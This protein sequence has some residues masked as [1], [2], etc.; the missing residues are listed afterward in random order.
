MKAA[1]IP[2]FLTRSWLREAASYLAAFFIF[3]LILLNRSPNVLRPL[4]MNIRFGFTWVIPVLAIVLYLCFRIPGRLGKFLSLTATLSLFALVLGGVWASGHTQ[5]TYISGLIPLYDAQNYYVDALRLL[6]GQRIS[7]FSAAR[8]LFTGFLATVLAITGRDLTIALMVLTAV[9]A[10]ACFFAAQTI[11][12]THGA[13]VAVFLLLFLF[14]YY[15]Y[16]TVGTVMSENVGFALGVTGITLLWRSIKNNSSQMAWY[17]LLLNAL[18][19]NARPGPFFILPALLLWGS[20]HFSKPD[21]HFSWRFFLAGIVAV[22]IGF[23]SSLLIKQFFGVE[24]GVPFSQFSYALYGLASG[25]NSWAYIFQVHPELKEMTQ[26]DL[27]WTAY[28]LTLDLVRQQ[29]ALILQGALHNWSTLFSNSWY[30]LFAYVGGENP[31]L[32]LI[33]R[34]FLY[35]LSVLGL[36]KWIRKPG[37][38]YASLIT[39][40]AV[41]IFISV[42]LVPPTDAYG[43]RLYAASSI[44]FGLLPAIGLC[45][46]LDQLKIKVKP[47]VQETSSQEMI[48]YSVLLVLLILVGPFLVSGTSRISQKPAT[49]CGPGMDSILAF[50]DAGTSIGLLKE[51]DPGMDW[52]PVFHYGHF[53]RNVHNLPDGH[54]VSRLENIDPHASLF[55]T[56]DYHSHREALIIVPTSML[57]PVRSIV[58]ICGQWEDDPALKAYS[59]FDAKSITALSEKQ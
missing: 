20:W 15:R 30:S 1:S 51:K 31:F 43:M 47:V 10:L 35:G 52:L 36:I 59:I 11:Q 29:P 19:L 55:Y 50:F 40:S 57:P 7:A 41:G 2:D 49:T 33:T 23:V 4:S 46:V 32:N 28:R 39:V 18:A 34:G 53:K 3:T 22:G 54:L 38:P 6:A 48:W 24:T 56:L 14:V 44:V 8:P 5:S 58:V 45:F 17:G 13:L 27:T 26:P 42:P 9:N 16:R 21:Q 12:S 25:G 37:D